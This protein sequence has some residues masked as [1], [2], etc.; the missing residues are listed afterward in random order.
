[1]NFLRG[2]VS[3]Y[4]KVLGVATQKQV[5]HGTADQIGL[6]ALGA[7]AG[8]Y[9]ESTVANIFTGDAVLVPGDNIQSGVRLTFGACCDAA[10]YHKCV[11]ARGKKGADE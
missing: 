9:L 2:C 7:Q 10:V 3:R 1:M 6:V 8:H 4:V 5:A 11:V